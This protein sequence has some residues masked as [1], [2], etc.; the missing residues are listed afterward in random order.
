MFVNELVCL[1]RIK[2]HVRNCVDFDG[3][4][5]LVLANKTCKDNSTTLNC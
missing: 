3:T 1:P 4:P 5:R 2:E